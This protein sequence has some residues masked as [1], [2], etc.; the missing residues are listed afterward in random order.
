LFARAGNAT[1]GFAVFIQASSAV[2]AA[3]DIQ[4]AFAREQ[5]PLAEKMSVRMALH[6][7]E[8]ELR[9]G[10]YYGTAVNRCARLR[11]IAHGRQVLMSRVTAELARG[12]LRPDGSLA[13]A[14]GVAASTRLWP[15]PRTTTSSTKPPSLPH[16][17]LTSQV[18]KP[19]IHDPKYEVQ[20]YGGTRL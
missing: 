9:A 2:A 3:F 19:S 4:R 16:L 17:V 5:W 18:C 8:A 1:A 7:G 20:E 13:V 15:S 14:G 10:D 6:T 11:A 12:K